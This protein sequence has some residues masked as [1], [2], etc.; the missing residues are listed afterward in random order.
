MAF[1]EF[2]KKTGRALAVTA[3][4][5]A[6]VAAGAATGAAVGVAAPGSDWAS[7]A[8]RSPAPRSPTLTAIRTGT[9]MGTHTI[10]M[11]AGMAGTMA[12]GIRR[13]GMVGTDTGT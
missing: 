3:A 12:A 5:G 8:A 6:A 1:M 11:A 2:A 7:W 9:A 13:T 10:T 4:V